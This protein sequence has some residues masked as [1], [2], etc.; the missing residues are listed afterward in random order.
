MK[1]KIFSLIVFSS[2]L[3]SFVEGQNKFEM[4]GTRTTVDTRDSIFDEWLTGGTIELDTRDF[5][6]ITLSSSTILEQQPSGSK[7]GT[8]VIDGGGNANFS[9]VQGTGSNGNSN[10]NLS[11]E[12]FLKHQNHLIIKVLRSIRFGFVQS[13]RLMQVQKKLLPSL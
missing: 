5:F 4:V 7:V 8:L 13:L 1:N 9:L 11:K 6:E 3:L 12:E 2:L 10:F